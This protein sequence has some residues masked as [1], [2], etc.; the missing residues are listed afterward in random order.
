MD[1]WHSHIAPDLHLHTI[2]AL[3]EQLKQFETQLDKAV[4]AARSEGISWD[5][6]GRAYGVTRQGARK[7]WDTLADDRGQ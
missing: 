3:A 1:Q 2:G 7:R 4:A 5:K 6:I